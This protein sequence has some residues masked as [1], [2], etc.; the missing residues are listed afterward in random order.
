[1]GC[2]NNS[3]DNGT[4]VVTQKHTESTMKKRLRKQA[5]LWYDYKV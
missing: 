5:V 2:R 3:G 4:M 1:M